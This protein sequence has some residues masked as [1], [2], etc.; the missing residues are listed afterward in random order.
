VSGRRQTPSQT[1]GPYFAIGMFPEHP[2]IHERSVTHLF[3]GALATPGVEG[4]RIR[5]EGRLHDGAGAP[6]PDAVLEVWQADGKGVYR[7]GKPANDGFTGFGRVS[8]HDEGRFVIDTVMPGPAPGPEGKPQAPHITLVV[9]M[10]G[11][12]VHA[13]TRIYFEG[14]AANAGDAIL[15]L[16]PAERRDTL[17]ARCKLGAPDAYVFDIHMQGDKETVF[18]DA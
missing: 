11:M 2:D 16:V 15:G 1:V 5:V 8:T 9:F 10:R 14:E 7:G 6:I 18:F 3:T 12:L 17:I 4:R 13:Y